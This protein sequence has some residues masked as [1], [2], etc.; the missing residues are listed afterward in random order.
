MLSVCLPIRDPRVF[1]CGD[2][3]LWSIQFVLFTVNALIKQVH[4]DEC[5]IVTKPFAR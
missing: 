5:R 4:V 1:N 2:V 3:V